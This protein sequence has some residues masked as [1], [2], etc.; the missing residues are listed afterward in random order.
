M[1]EMFQ[2]LDSIKRINSKQQSYNLKKLLTKA[3]FSNQEV[4]VKSAKI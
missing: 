1:R 4:G 3:E 2:A